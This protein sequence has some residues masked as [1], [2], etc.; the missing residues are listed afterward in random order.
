MECSA[1]SFFHAVELFRHRKHHAI[2]GGG[3]IGFVANSLNQLYTGSQKVFVD[4]F[5]RFR[6]VV[7]WPRFS[8]GGSDAVALVNMEHIV[9][10]QHGNDGRFDFSC[11]AV[12]FL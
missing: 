3:I 2:S 1:E 12:L 5:F 8:V 11:L 4:Y 7:H 10:S 9:V 6:V